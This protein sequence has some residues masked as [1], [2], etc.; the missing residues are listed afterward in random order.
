MK[1]VLILLL[2]LLPTS[3]TWLSCGGS[4]P[5][6][7]TPTSGLKYRAFITNNVSAGTAAAGIYIVDAVNDVRATGSPI[8]VGNTPGMMVVTPN[9][10]QT[11]VFSGNGTQFSDNVFSVINNASEMNA[12]HVTLPGMTESF[13][14]SPDSSTAYVAVPSAS[15]VGQPSLGAVQVIGLSSGTVTATISCPPLNPNPPNPPP[16]P[17]C[18]T[19]GQG[20]QGIN[21]PYQFLFI[22]NTGARLLAF[23]EGPDPV[24]DMIAVITPSSIET[25]NPVVTFIPGFDHPVAAFFSSDDSTAYVLNCGP[26]CGG[27]QASI[28]TLDLTTNTAGPSGVVCTPGGDPPCIGTVNL[29]AGSVALLNGS[30]MYV[31][32]TPASQPC[33]G[34]TT[35]ATTCGVL[36]TVDLNTMTVT[37]PPVQPPYCPAGQQCPIIITDGYH[38][39][40]AL[41]ANGQLFIGARTCTEIFAPVPPVTGAEVRGCLSIYNTL[42]TPVAS[43]PA[44]GVVIPPENG[45]VTGIQPIATRQVVYVVQGQSVPQGGTLY[46]YD[47]TIDALEYNPNDQ[48]NPGQVSGLIGN[49]FDVKTVDF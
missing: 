48:Y 27:T 19:Q 35:A 6:G 33:T 41:G 1:R 21:L 46:I 23:S 7:T 9:R 11:L 42:T 4:S 45:D 32:G 14:V 24:A 43:V 10:A 20:D 36:T 12:A 5:S 47:D 37:Q 3:L 13:V 39:R 29:V 2:F 40:I 28:Q 18:V 26:E 25:A 34:Q 22:G 38:N 31:A 30:T 15:V 44:G 16:P 17:V 49:F 8:S